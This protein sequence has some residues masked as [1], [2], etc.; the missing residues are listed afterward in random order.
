MEDAGGGPSGDR[1]RHHDGAV[2]EIE[3][4]GDAEY[5]RETRGAQ[6]I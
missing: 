6:R 2:G 4:T 5:Q 3:D 1:S